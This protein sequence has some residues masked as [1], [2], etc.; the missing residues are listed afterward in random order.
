[1][2]SVSS[3]TEHAVS[4]AAGCGFESRTECHIPVALVH[5]QNCKKLFASTKEWIVRPGDFI[6]QFRAEGSAP[7]IECDA[8]AALAYE[9][10]KPEKETIEILRELRASVDD[11]LPGKT[12]L[13]HDPPKAKRDEQS[14][15]RAR[16]RYAKW[17]IPLAIAFKERGEMT[18]RQIAEVMGC[19]NATSYMA[20]NM[21]WRARNSGFDLVVVNRTKPLHGW[22]VSWYGLKNGESILPP[23][24]S[25]TKKFMKEA[26][27]A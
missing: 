22:E 17:R 14:Q 6:E 10:K 19:K 3:T 8:C 13:L 20:H 12:K 15:K 1:M 5:C 2:N 23:Q 21:L 26:A 11:A 9:E 18:A 24:D 7:I 4:R 16:R 25:V 27:S